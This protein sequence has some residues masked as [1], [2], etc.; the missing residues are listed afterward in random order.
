MPMSLENRPKSPLN[1]QITCKIL[2]ALGFR[3]V[4]AKRKLSLFAAGMPPGRS[5]KLQIGVAIA[6]RQKNSRRRATLRARGASFRPGE[7][8][9]KNVVHSAASGW[10]R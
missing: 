9:S 2:V 7:G 10:G 4:R 5:E 3:G 1:I 8:L 6:Q